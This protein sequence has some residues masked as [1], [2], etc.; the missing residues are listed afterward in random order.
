MGHVRNY[1]IGDVLARFMR[2]QGRNVC[3]PGLGRVRPAGRE[4]GDGEHG[5]ARAL[6]ARQHRLHARPAQ[7]ARPRHRLESRARH[8]RCRLL[9]LEPVAVP[10]HAREG[11]RVQEVRRR[12]LGSG[13]QDGPCQRAGDRRP[14]LAHRRAGGEARDPDVL[15]AHHVVRRRVAAGARHVAGLARARTRD[16]GQLDRPQRR[17]RRRV[18]VC[19]RHAARAGSRWAP[20]RLHHPRRHAV[21]RHLRRG[22]GRASGGGRRRGARRTHC[23]VR[24]RVSPRQHDGGRRRDARETGHRHRPARAASADRRA[25][26]GVRRQTTC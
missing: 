2:M 5:A 23:R 8:L 9:P 3:S 18:S 17:R 22:G 24:R 6:D 13:G 12:Q 21:R 14:R 7:V 26:A 19:A 11:H 4:R 1:T 15:P 25:A 16:A 20:A 10:A